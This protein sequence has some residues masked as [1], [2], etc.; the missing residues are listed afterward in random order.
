MGGGGGGSWPASHRTRPWYP[1]KLKLMCLG[2]K[3]SPVYPPPTPQGVA[4]QYFGFAIGHYLSK[5]DLGRCSIF[6][7]HLKQQ[8][9]AKTSVRPPFSYINF[10]LGDIHRK[11][12]AVRNF[13]FAFSLSAYFQILFFLRNHEKKV[14]PTLNRKFSIRSMHD[15]HFIWSL[16]R[17]SNRPYLWVR[18]CW[19][20][21]S[22]L[23]K[24]IVII[25]VFCNGFFPFF[26]LLIYFSSPRQAERWMIE[27]KS[28]LLWPIIVTKPCISRWYILPLRSERY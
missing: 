26:Y 23:G 3:M 10:W 16:L 21:L 27:A 24:F 6:Y 8:R 4:F 20:L 18:L 25:V 15:V 11:R 2:T 5:F 9:T 28:N 19:Q 22:S 13:G 14:P 1:C 12:K 17:F 7:G